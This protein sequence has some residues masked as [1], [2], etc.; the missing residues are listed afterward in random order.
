VV[1]RQYVLSPRRNRMASSYLVTPNSDSE[2]FKEKRYYD[3]MGL[4]VN[5]S[6]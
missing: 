1:D 6:R 2:N 4:Y 3:I 5:R